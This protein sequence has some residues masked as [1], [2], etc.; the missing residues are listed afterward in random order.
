MDRTGRFLI[1][2]PGITS[3]FFRKSVIFIYEDTNL[4]SAGINISKP[5][6]LTLRDVDP[7]KAVDYVAADPVI[8]SGGPVNKRAVMMLHS[9]DFVSTNTLFLTDKLS[10]SSDLLMVEK[11][12]MGNWPRQFRL[13]AGA[14]IWQSGQLDFEF[15]RNMWLLGDLDSDKIFDL[16]Q[17]ELWGWAVEQVA[18]QTIARYF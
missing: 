15:N 8:Y 14:C 4:G 12:Y 16:D 17:E 13:T 9:N 6:N 5:T 18:Q 10:L 3:G 1:S 11:M 2:R 7:Q